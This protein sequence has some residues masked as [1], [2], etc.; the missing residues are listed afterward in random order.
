MKIFNIQPGQSSFSSKKSVYVSK[1]MLMKDRIMS[2]NPVIARK[3]DLLKGIKAASISCLA[4]DEILKE[5]GLTFCNVDKN[6]I[7]TA[8][9]YNGGFYSVKYDAQATPEQL[10]A[11]FAQNISDDNY[12]RLGGMLNY[13][14]MVDHLKRQDIVQKGLQ[15]HTY[16]LNSDVTEEDAIKTTVLLSRFSKKFIKPKQLFFIDKD[17]FYYDKTEKIAYSIPIN[18]PSDKKA[19]YAFRTCRFMTDN[20][21][22]ATG[23]TQNYFDL[24][25]KCRIDKTYE[26][27]QT[28]SDQLPPVADASNNKL[29]AEAFRFGNTGQNIWQFDEAFSAISNHLQRKLGIDFVTKDMIQVVKLQDKDER[30]VL[31]IC[32]YDSSIGRSLVYDE[33]GKYL[34]Q[35]EYHKD[36]FGKIRA[37]SKY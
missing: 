11:Y 24:F 37:C 1:K 3:Q 9:G 8:A 31:R 30:P 26:E 28:P 21:N 12:L 5:N 23:Y 20:K 27:Q 25:Q 17:A 19:E 14:E 35:M 32:F 22:N 13:K 15:L 34:F 29:Y 16:E 4:I 2:I 33:K 10:K 7:H 18:T 36:A 6:T